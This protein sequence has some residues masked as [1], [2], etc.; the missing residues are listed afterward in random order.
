M[1]NP[2]ISSEKGRNGPRQVRKEWLCIVLFVTGILLSSCRPGK[3]NSLF[4][5]AA[6]TPK[7]EANTRIFRVTA[8]PSRPAAAITQLLPTST[9]LPWK[10]PTG[11]I[12]SSPTPT[13]SATAA[14]PPAR[15]PTSTPIGPCAERRPGDGLLELVD[16]NYGLSR[17]FKPSDLIGLNDYL[18]IKVTKG[19]PTE[20]REVI[21]YQL[22]AMIDAMVEEGLQPSII[23]G[24]RD[25]SAQAIAWA[26]WLEKEPTRVGIISAP[27]GFSE[28]QLGTTLDF[29][30]PELAFIVG[31]ENVE[32]HT[33]FY[34][35]SEGLWL[36]ENAHFYGFSLS[37]PRET[38][39]LTG[40][41]YEPWHYRY[42]GVQLATQLRNRGMSL[43]E[44]LIEN[45]PEQCIP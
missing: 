45:E 8:V 40:F 14:P 24:Y 17:E 44:Y 31:D 27:P 26:K 21:I 16:R 28:H 42:V 4:D 22:V 30:S 3:N 1:L 15:T 29:G 19:Y 7:I 32:F 37:Y 34:K 9:S 6:I 23:S 5:S 39:E 41:F 13:P 20:V 43:I 35:T 10:T 33:Y 36:A 11:Q 25:Y 12:V 38:F 18:P 2:V